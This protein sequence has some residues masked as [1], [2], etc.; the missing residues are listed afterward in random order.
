MPGGS[1]SPTSTGSGVGSHA[2]SLASVSAH[3]LT[4]LQRPLFHF[5]HQCMWYWYGLSSCYE[6]WLMCFVFVQHHCRALAR[7][8]IQS[9]VTDARFARVRFRPSLAR[10][11]LSANAQAQLVDLWLLVIKPWAST[12]YKRPAHV[13]LRAEELARADVRLAARAAVAHR[14]CSR[15]SAPAR[16]RDR[17]TVGCRWRA[18]SFTLFNVVDQV[19]RKQYCHIIFFIFFC[20]CCWSLM[21]LV[22][23][24]ASRAEQQ[25]DLEFWHE[26][27]AGTLAYFT[28]LT[29]D[30]LLAASE[31]DFSS[32]SDRRLLSRVVVR[33]AE[34]RTGRH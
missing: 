4:A 19:P 2:L 15:T 17:T 28:T 8:S 32:S 3:G 27:V 6:R 14:V 31:L 30:M 24:V 34:Q 23:V 22:V 7:R 12:F 9:S 18:A 26:Y 25:A 1:P 29:A 33:R 20:C 21:C 5:L 16:S 11:R 13:A 10:R